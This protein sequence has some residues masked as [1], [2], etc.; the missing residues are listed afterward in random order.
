MTLRL[1]L[2]L[3]INAKAGGGGGALSSAKAIQYGNIMCFPFTDDLLDVTGNHDM[4]QTPVG[5]VPSLAAEGPGGV[6][7]VDFAGASKYLYSQPAPPADLSELTNITVAFAMKYNRGGAVVDSAFCQGVPDRDQNY[8][9]FPSYV[10]A[11]AGDPLWGQGAG[12]SS[13]RY[14]RWTD[15]QAPN[16]GAWHHYAFSLIAPRSGS[17]LVVWFLDGALYSQQVIDPFDLPQFGDRFH[18]GGTG[19]STYG[20]DGYLRNFIIAD[21]LLSTE[22]AELSAE[23]LGT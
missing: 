16:D 17:N 7:V 4:T 14:T 13:G 8:G 23:A 12:G 6:N 21:T 1:D 19:N 11:F 5:N 18:L 3:G 2:G 9:F 22:I 15:A 20:L 10:G